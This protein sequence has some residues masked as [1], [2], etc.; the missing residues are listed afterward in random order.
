MV[1][2]DGQPYA[3]YALTLRKPTRLSAD[4]LPGLSGINTLVDGRIWAASFKIP[5]LSVALPAGR[6]LGVEVVGVVSEIDYSGIFID[7]KGLLPAAASVGRTVNAALGVGGVE[8]SEHPNYYVVRIRRID[9]NA[10]DMVA[11][12]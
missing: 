6:V 3:A 8:V 1:V 9:Q 10:S 11:V 4:L 5:G 2:K 12:F 7:E